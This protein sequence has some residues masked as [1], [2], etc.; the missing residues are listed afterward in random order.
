MKAVFGAKGDLGTNRPAEM[1]IGD[2]VIIVSD[3]GTPGADTCVPL[4]LRR[5]H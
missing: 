4:G 3:G 1:R 5:G 2:S